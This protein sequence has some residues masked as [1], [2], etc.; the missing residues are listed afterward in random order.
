LLGSK[1]CQIIPQGGQRFCGSLHAD[2]RLFST[3]K[4]KFIKALY[5]QQ[6]LEIKRHILRMKYFQIIG[7][8]ALQ[9]NV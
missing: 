9:K 7:E 8:L 4:R 5:K 6:L 2:N 3:R 1:H